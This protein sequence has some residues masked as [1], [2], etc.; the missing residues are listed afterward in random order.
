MGGMATG[1]PRG[2]VSVV[3]S[4]MLAAIGAMLAHAQDDAIGLVEGKCADGVAPFEAAVPD[5][6]ASESASP[7]SSTSGAP[8]GRWRRLLSTPT[9]T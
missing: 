9:Q 8:G 7:A 1:R 2:L 4:L 6:E 5:E 3:A